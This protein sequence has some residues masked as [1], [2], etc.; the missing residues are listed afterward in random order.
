MN[1][2]EK[3][4]WDQHQ[5]VIGID[6]AGRGPMAGPLVVC[7]VVLPVD[8]YNPII[9]DSKKLT[10]T[11]RNQCFLDIIADAQTIIIEIVS[12]ETIDH[13]NIYKATQVAMENIIKQANLPAI[14]DAMP[15]N[16]QQRTQSI[17][18]GDQKS[19]SIAAASIIAKV[20]RDKI[21]TEL[22]L[23]YPDYGFKQHKGYPTKAHKQAINELG[24]SVVHRQSFMF[25]DES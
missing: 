20:T 1:Q 2:F 19:I 10:E 21:M 24:R 15:V 9:T 22:D 14:I 13:L 17:I 8:Y 16:C 23:Q 6:E 7:G 12:P 11:K 25:K 5:F 18:K 3:E 4:F